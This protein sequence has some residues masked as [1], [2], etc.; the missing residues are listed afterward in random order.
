MT[1][2]TKQGSE[3]TVPRGAVALLGYFDGF[4]RGHQALAAAAE[5]LKKRK[6]APC[7]A[8]WTFDRL[9]K[10]KALT[11]NEEKAEAF[12]SYFPTPG[13]AVA[14]FE[15]FSRLRGLSGEEFVRDVLKGQFDFC[16]V[17]CGFNFR[18]GKDGSCG[19]AEL[20]EYGRRYGIETCVVPAFAPD[21]ETVSSS[22]IRRYI[23][24]GDAL[25]AMELMGRPYSI[26]APALH[27][28]QIGRTLGFPTVNQRIPENKTQPARGVY[29]CMARL[30][31]GRLKLGVCNIGN[32]PTVNDDPSD[33]TL[34]TFLLDFSGDLYGG[35]ITIYLY[36]RLRGETRFSST[37]ALS[38]QIARDKEETLAF[39]GKSCYG[40]E[41]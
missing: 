16:A 35:R 6:G 18:F 32:R 1:I 31:D 34:E 37:E 29:A 10:G 23:E 39:F 33:V 15:E 14:V 17:V 3:A 4:H 38:A 12:F 9:P 27:G 5:R 25:R 2:R 30:P 20:T 21:G 24:E 19:A 8:L 41:I 7:V 40:L 11:D 22:R 13:E 26:T 28:K 36:K